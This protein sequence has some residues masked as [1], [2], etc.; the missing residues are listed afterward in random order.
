MPALRTPRHH[1]HSVCLSP[2]ISQYARQVACGH[3]LL[4]ARGASG[5]LLSN[6]VFSFPPRDECE[7]EAGRYLIGTLEDF[8]RSQSVYR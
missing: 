2:Q 1:R 8:T 5:H 7:T 3:N 4:P 6:D